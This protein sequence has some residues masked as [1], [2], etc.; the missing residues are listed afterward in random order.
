MNKFIF[1]DIDGVMNSNL[2]YSERTQD[3]RYNELLKFHPQRLAW[4]LCNIDP[5][6][7]ARLNRITKATNAL[8]IVS[9]SWRFD[10]NL[11]E[12]FTLSGIEQRIS[13]RTPWSKDRFR[14]SEIQEWL[15]KQT[16]PYRYVILDDDNDMLDSQLPYFIQTDWLKWGLSDEDVEQ[17]I[18]ILNADD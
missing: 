11:Q 17:A 3:K 15:D 10:D 2:F 8:I 4:S 16:E 7:V 9:S 18:H 14:G 1:L 6:A 5:R 13:D 12:V